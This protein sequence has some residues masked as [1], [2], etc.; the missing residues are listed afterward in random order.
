MEF[1]A[2]QRLRIRQL[3]EL[4][5]LIAI[6]ATFYRYGPTWRLPRWMHHLL[7]V[8][9][10]ISLFVLYRIIV[11]T[12]ERQFGS[13]S[14]SES[15]NESE[16]E[17]Q[18]RGADGLQRKQYQVPRRFGIATMAVA[19]TSIALVAGVLLSAG[20]PHEGVVVILGL[21]SIVT[22][23]QAVVDRVPRSASILAGMIYFTSIIGFQVWNSQRLGPQMAAALLAGIVLG[24][25]LGYVTGTA[26]AGLFLAADAMQTWWRG[27]HAPTA[28]GEAK[29]SPWD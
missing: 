19:T 25:A 6:A 14:E 28:N 29:Q 10:P 26:V 21:I 1:S 2:K 3:A 23:M 11:H 24:S 4:L 7:I 17:S 27:S 13:A 22:V 5:L 12:V 15:T 9:T 18:R 8:V 16:S 20:V